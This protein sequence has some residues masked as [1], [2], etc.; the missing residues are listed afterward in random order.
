V[1]LLPL[2]APSRLGAAHAPGYC[3]LAARGRGGPG[4]RLGLHHVDCWALAGCYSG[5]GRLCGF[6]AGRVGAVAV[7]T[8]LGLRR[9]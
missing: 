9:R 2:G 7:R 6:A 5:A 3:G 1:D 8:S 4:T